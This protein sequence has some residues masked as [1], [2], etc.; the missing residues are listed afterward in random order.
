MGEQ[1]QKQRDGAE[2]GKGGGGQR[3]QG[4]GTTDR[5]GSERGAQEMD[6]HRPRGA[7]AQGNTHWRGEKEEGGEYI[8]Q[9]SKRSSHGR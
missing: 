1:G 5:G 9:R 2:Q 3:G 4:S 6:H 8:I 7:A